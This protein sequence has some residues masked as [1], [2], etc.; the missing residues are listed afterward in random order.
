MPSIKNY[1]TDVILVV[2]H[3]ELQSSNMCWPLSEYY[4]YRLLRKS[5]KASIMPIIQLRD[6]R[7][8]QTNP[9]KSPRKELCLFL[10]VF[11]SR[12]YPIYDHFAIGGKRHTDTVTPSSTGFNMHHWFHECSNTENLSTVSS[13]RL[14]VAFNFLGFRLYHCMP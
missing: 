4:S 9:Q 2:K 1:C 3:T 14:N 5:V 6:R 11:L 10:Y 13:V 8:A 12:A 7:Q